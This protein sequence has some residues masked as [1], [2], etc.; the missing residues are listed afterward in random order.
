[1]NRYPTIGAALGVALSVPAA[2][3]LAPRGWLDL[4]GLGLSLLLGAA[5][6]LAGAMI[7]R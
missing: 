1:M 4:I 2:I 3:Y 6:A 7:Q 5:G